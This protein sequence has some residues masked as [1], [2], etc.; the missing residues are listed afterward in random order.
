M[1]PR[2][3]AL[4]MTPFGFMTMTT[5]T[6]AAYWCSVWTRVVV[7]NFYSKNEVQLPI[8]GQ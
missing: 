8:R 7:P 1:D 5:Y 3:I 6:M 2:M 4:S